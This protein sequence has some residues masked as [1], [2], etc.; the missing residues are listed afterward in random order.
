[1]VGGTLENP[2]LVGDTLYISLCVFLTNIRRSC[3]P[4]SVQQIKI[5]LMSNT[6]E[7]KGTPAAPGSVDTLRVCFQ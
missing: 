3:R 6:T 4:N 5:Y 2:S 1:M 7:E